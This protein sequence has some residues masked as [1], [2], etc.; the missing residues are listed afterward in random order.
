MHFFYTKFSSYLFTFI[1]IINTAQ[2]CKYPKIFHKLAPSYNHVFKVAAT[3]A[4]LTGSYDSVSGASTEIT[5]PTNVSG[6]E[7]ENFTYRITTSPRSA[8]N[9]FAEKPNFWQK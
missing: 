7:G 9:F 8:S 3:S 6:T 2:K 4:I 1:I 5:S